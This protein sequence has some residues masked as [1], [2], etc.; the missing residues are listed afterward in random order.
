M[1]EHITINLNISSS[2]VLTESSKS[3]AE[4]LFGVELRSEADCEYLPDY[5]RISYITRTNG[6]HQ[7]L[8]QESEDLHVQGLAPLYHFP[9][10]DDSILFLYGKS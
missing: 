10:G 5:S 3:P 8:C 7:I 6:T 9:A 1:R 2:A 4:Q